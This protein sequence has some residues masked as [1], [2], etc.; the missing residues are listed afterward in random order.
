MFLSVHF[1]NDVDDE[2]KT[3]VQKLSRDRYGSE[4][5]LRSISIDPCAGGMCAAC[6]LVCASVV[7]CVS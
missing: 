4:G 3:Q 6:V 5:V 7:P 1:V 2:K